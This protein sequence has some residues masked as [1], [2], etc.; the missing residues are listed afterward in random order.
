[1]NIQFPRNLVPVAKK[2]P[3][4]VTLIGT[5]YFSSGRRATG[6]SPIVR[7]LENHR[8]LGQVLDGGVR[9]PSPTPAATPESQPLEALGAGEWLRAFG[10]LS[11]SPQEARNIVDKFK[12][13]D[14]RVR[15]VRDFC[16]GDTSCQSV[17]F[18]T[19]LLADYH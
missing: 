11:V 19:S 14:I 12:K 1:M 18:L 13:F 3:S 7:K 4:I 16:Q 5:C 6:R 9:L 8:K 15:S 2:L 17:S 10:F